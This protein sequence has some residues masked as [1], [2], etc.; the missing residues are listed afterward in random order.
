MSETDDIQTS[1]L[2]GTWHRIACITLA[3]IDAYS[4]VEPNADSNALRLTRLPHL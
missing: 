2:S 4:A 1:C 3:I